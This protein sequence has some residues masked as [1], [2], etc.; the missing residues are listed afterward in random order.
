MMTNHDGEMVQYEDPA[1]D[2]IILEFRA[3]AI[4]VTLDQ[5][6]WLFD[7]DEFTPL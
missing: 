1:S 6:E 3:P 5:A 4:S 7:R 2:G